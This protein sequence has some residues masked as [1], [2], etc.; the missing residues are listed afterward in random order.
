[1]AHGMNPST[2]PSVC[3][4]DREARSGAGRPRATLSPLAGS[5]QIS[6]GDAMTNPKTWA[7]PLDVIG[8]PASR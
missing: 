4:G 2:I 1:M 5:D 7:D 6:L 3:D 8:R